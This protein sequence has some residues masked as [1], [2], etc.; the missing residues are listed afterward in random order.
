MLSE[1][2]FRMVLIGFLSIFL[3]SSSSFAKY[4]S[5]Q[6][7]QPFSN[8]TPINVV[9]DGTEQ[10]IILIGNSEDE[11][12]IRLNLFWFFS[13]DGELI[14]EKEIDQTTIGLISKAAYWNSGKLILVS[15][16][17]IDDK[18]KSLPNVQILILST[19]TIQEIHNIATLKNIDMTF[20]N[21]LLVDQQDEI[22][23]LLSGSHTTLFQGQRPRNDWQ[24]RLD[25]FG[26]NGE[27]RWTTEIGNQQDNV[28]GQL[29]KLGQFFYV[30]Y[31]TWVPG[32][33][34]NVQMVGLD[35]FGQV[36]NEKT[37][38]YGSGSDL[39]NSIEKIDDEHFILIGT[40]DSDHNDL[41]LPKGKSD[42][43]ILK[44]DVDGNI[45]WSRRLGGQYRD[46]GITGLYDGHETI[47]IAGMTESKDGDILDNQGGWDIWIIQLDRDGN[48]LENKCFGT[49]NNEN[50][51]QFVQIENNI[52]LLGAFQATATKTQPLLIRINE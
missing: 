27:K 14:A 34:W 42:L 17:P 48:I 8:I 5:I 33:R 23:L 43:I 26:F 15:V 45:K 16:L 50:P 32:Q 36:I 24:I 37:I 10:K 20:N 18:N 21:N 2:L 40:T 13:K 49:L 46:I 44:F 52:W 38:L 47:W 19:N 4:L 25:C 31:N 9:W 39:V 1:K 29:I 30:V 12:G 51:I 11:N 3:F 28:M 22:I 41:G 7:S 35:H 6:S